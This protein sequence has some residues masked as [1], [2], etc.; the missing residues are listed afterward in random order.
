MREEEREK[1]RGGRERSTTKKMRIRDIPT[2][3]SWFVGK[4][5]REGSRQGGGVLR[6]SEV[7]REEGGDENEKE[8]EE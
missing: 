5:G 4:E 6:W 2:H 3:S 8:R 7:R 1:E